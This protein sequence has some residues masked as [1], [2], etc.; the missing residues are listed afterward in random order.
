VNLICAVQ[1]SDLEYHNIV[2]QLN[3][4]RANDR[5]SKSSGKIKDLEEQLQ[6]SSTKSDCTN[7]ILKDVIPKVYFSR[8]SS[9]TIRQ[10]V[11]FGL[12]N[13]FVCV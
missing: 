4:K 5:Y 3:L 12:R 13:P 8:T 9:E 2:L 6:R 7:K 11:C 10:R 1:I